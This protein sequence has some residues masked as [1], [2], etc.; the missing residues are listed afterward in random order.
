MPFG[1]QGAG[2]LVTSLAALGA[3][4]YFQFYFAAVLAGFVAWAEVGRRLA[5]RA[6]STAPPPD[7]F[8][9]QPPRE[10]RGEESRSVE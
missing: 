8:A 4:L 1:A 5:P 10:T 7:L 2:F 3:A 9:P 6:P